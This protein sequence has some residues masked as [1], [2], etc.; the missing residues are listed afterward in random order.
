MSSLAT[1]CAIEY[2]FKVF[3]VWAVVKNSY[4]M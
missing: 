4:N 2:V 3:P 1:Y